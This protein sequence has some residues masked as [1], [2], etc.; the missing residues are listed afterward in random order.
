MWLLIT[1]DRDWQDAPHCAL[2]IFVLSVTQFAA[3][4]VQDYLFKV[5]NVF[6]DVLFFK[7]AYVNITSWYESRLDVAVV[8]FPPTQIYQFIL[9]RLF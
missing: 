8:Y 2:N 4:V 9:I 1:L 3:I 5:E 6:A 7:Q